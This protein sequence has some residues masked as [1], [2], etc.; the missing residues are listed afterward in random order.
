M[1]SIISKKERKVKNNVKEI[2][3]KKSQQLYQNTLIIS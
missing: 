3:V 1:K 2:F